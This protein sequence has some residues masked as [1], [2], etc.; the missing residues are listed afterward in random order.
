MLKGR[1]KIG[2]RAAQ[3]PSRFGETVIKRKREWFDDDSFWISFYP[4]MFPDQKFIQ[5]E[6]LLGKV[7]KLS[8]AKG[9]DVLDLCCGPGRFSIPLAKR[10]FR[11]TGVDRTAFLLDQAKRKAKTAN[12]RIEWVQEDM[13]SF[14]RPES[15]DLVLSMFTSFGYFDDKDE[16]I[17]VLENIWTS[18]RLGGHG[19]RRPGDRFRGPL[20]LARPRGRRLGALSI[21]GAG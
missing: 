1:F 2:A 11:V 8:G 19:R 14:I 18:H 12:V 20:R 21:L 7:L 9:R 4:F 17:Q 10:K 6:E 15:F 3:G 16:D 5:A 13:R